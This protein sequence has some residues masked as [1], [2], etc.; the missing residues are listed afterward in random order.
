MSSAAAEPHSGLQRTAGVER[1]G[2]T[3]LSEGKRLDPA[4][5]P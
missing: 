2:S 4:I 5:E 3:A 1:G